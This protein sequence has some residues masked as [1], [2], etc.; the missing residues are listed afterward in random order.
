MSTQPQRLGILLPLAAVVAAM[1]AFQVGAAFAKGL[2]PAIGPEGAATLRLCFAA[3]ML[4][5]VTRPW[6]AW[7]RPAPLA[8]LLGLGSCVAAVIWMFY[9]AIAHLPLGEA[10]AL[11][12]LGPLAIAIFD[13]R[14]PSDLVWAAL[15][16]FGVWLLVAAGSAA[17]KI[18]LVGIA[19]ALGA[20]ASWGGYI[21][22]GR[23]ASGAFGAST[24]ALSISVAAV[25][26]LPVG[27]LHA[28]AGLLSP[29]ILPTALLVAL[30]SAAIPFSLEMFAMPRMPRRTFAVF[31]S[32]E[33]AFGTLS[34]LVIL[35]ERLTPAQL[36]GVAGVIA[37]AAGAAW[38]SGGD[39]TPE[40]T[41]GPAA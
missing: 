28:G 2:F 10:I 23:A 12:F 14:R 7:P 26:I 36:C 13:S 15:A 29:A 20:A 18:D 5:A 9:K 17:A 27:V 35:H 1:A 38:T 19:W 39:K 31:T 34:G 16:A 24:A 6:R 40:V 21:L 32:L 22:F 37:A 8:P 11:Q 25:V 41:D 3:P 30:F 33:P 4:L